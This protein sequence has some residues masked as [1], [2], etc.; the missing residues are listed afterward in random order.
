MRRRVMEATIH[1]GDLGITVIDR[2][3]QFISELLL[4]INFN[5]AKEGDPRRQIRRLKQLAHLTRSH[6]RLE[7]GMMAAARYPGLAVHTLRHEWMMEQIRR[8]AAY[9]TGQKNAMTR[10]PMGL[11]WESHT[12]HMESEDRAFGLWLDVMNLDVMN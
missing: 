2:D 4:E 5:A 10:E 12:A 3:H 11:L 6:F 1:G 7:E 8:L 9:F